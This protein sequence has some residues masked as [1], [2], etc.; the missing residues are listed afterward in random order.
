[1]KTFSQF[2]EQILTTQQSNINAAKVNAN[3]SIIR[4]HN[5]FA[6]RQRLHT[7][8]HLAQTAAQERKGMKG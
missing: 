6:N 1:M 3:A 2:M 4:Q 8:L 7:N 5:L